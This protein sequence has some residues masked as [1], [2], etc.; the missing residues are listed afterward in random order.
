MARIQPISRVQIRK[1]LAKK[2]IRGRLEII[3]INSDYSEFN[4]E[5]EEWDELISE[6]AFLTISR[7]K[8]IV[9]MTINYVE[10]RYYIEYI[11]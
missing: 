7:F 11:G 5:R 3:K 4:P 10:R 8:R 2:G 6:V 1:L 9:K